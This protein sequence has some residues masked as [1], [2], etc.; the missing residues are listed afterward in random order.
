MKRSTFLL[1]MNSG[2]MTAGQFAAL[3]AATSPLAWWD[4]NRNLYTDTGLTTPVVNDGDAV[5]GW[6]DQGSTVANVTQSTAGNR[7]VYRVS[8]AA[9]NNKSAVQFTA[10]STHYLV[11]TGLAAGIVANLNAY[12]IYVVYVTSTAAGT[13]VQYAEGHDVNAVPFVQIRVN[14][15]KAEGVH[16]SDAAV[17]A[18]PANADTTA[19]NGIKHIQTFVRVDANNFA[20]RQ[21]GVQLGTAAATPVAT[22][23]DQVAVGALVRNAVASPFDGHIAQVIISGSNNFAVIEPILAAFYGITLG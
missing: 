13:L 4:A 8:V 16:K 11:K 14:A 1:L 17:V 7:P 10:A 3:I 20:I 21:N 2:A 19:S 9:L 23:L 22:T 18:Q 12:C 5:A 15:S 6:K